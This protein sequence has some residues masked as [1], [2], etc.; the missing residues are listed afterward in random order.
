MS[1]TVIPLYNLDLG[2]DEQ[3]PFGKKFSLQRVPQWFKED[4]GFHG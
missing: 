3:V 1:F 2:G 4:K